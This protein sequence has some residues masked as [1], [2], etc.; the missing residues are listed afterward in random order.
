MSSNLKEQQQSPEKRTSES[1]I[2]TESEATGHVSSVSEEL[3]PRRVYR[4]RADSDHQVRQTPR[5]EEETEMTTGSY[6]PMGDLSR[7][8]RTS[9]V[10]TALSARQVAD[11]RPPPPQL[12]A[13]SIA[14]DVPEISEA[15]VVEVV[16]DDGDR[17]HESA[18]SQRPGP[19]P[20][21]PGV[22]T[23]G[24]AK[25]KLPAA[26]ASKPAVAVELRSEPEPTYSDE[27][28]QSGGAES[29]R[30]IS[31]A[32]SVPETARS[33]LAIA[34]TAPQVMPAP[35]A[36]AL[37]S[38]APASEKIPTTI[39]STKAAQADA[40]P[41]APLTTKPAAP[42]VQTEVKPQEK[43][44]APL[45]QTKVKPQEKPAAPLVQTEV[46]PQEKPAA[47]PAIV[48]RDVKDQ[49]PKLAFKLGDRVLV[50]GV[51]YGTVRY[52]GI[53]KLSS[54]L[55]VGVELDTP[56]GRHD[57]RYE[58][59]E[60]Y[61]ECRPNHGIF[62][63]PHR[64][65]LIAPKPTEA[66]AAAGQ[67][68]PSEASAGTT[69]SLSL[70]SKL[71]PEPT[72]AA[73]QLPAAP[74]GKR[75]QLND[76]QKKALADAITEQLVHEQIDALAV[77]FASKIPRAKP[78]TGTPSP[79]PAPASAPAASAGKLVTPPSAGGV[80]AA[81][82]P[83]PASSASQPKLPAPAPPAA[84]PA[85]AL[86]PASSKPVGPSMLVL[87]TPPQPR[88]PPGLI[89]LA[90]STVFGKN[91]DA[92]TSSQAVLEQASQKLSEMSK[93]G[94]KQPP[95]KD[96]PVPTPSSET[97]QALTPAYPTA[98][99][100]KPPAPTPPVEKTPAPT[101]TPAVDKPP[102]VDTEK[103]KEDATSLIKKPEHHEPPKKPAV[104]IRKLYSA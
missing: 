50:G 94:D 36:P 59:G 92:A 20:P 42:L 102:A 71:V 52:I 43:P 18:Q 101:P 57:G 26:A 99:E 100:I 64:V 84:A 38:T 74:A 93:L 24:D 17:T 58:G 68:G 95:P 9:V 16:A 10:H 27:F 78:S 53:P 35:P 45:V 1:S 77:L 60:R 2:A 90:S 61:F 22:P 14:S 72:P 21:P 54:G 66:A 19:P 13:R 104:P 30:S 25:A 15:E 82:P 6:V 98:A 4:E 80:P 75:D 70:S 51:H 76:A 5:I 37:L 79:A 103:P 3:S 34:H 40:K 33:E 44:V 62:A 89:S 87:Q 55:M 28:E 29:V 83:T 23:K 85:P 65:V 63:P 48:E 47:P 31:T 96:T 88:P 11:E 67:K 86:A 81:P 41:T 56:E 39:T 97:P 91:A 46:K 73:R 69:V 8:S 32:P 49:V 12:S 7:S